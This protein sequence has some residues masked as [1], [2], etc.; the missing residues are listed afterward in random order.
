MDAETYLGFRIHHY[1][2]IQQNFLLSSGEQ[3]E[4]LL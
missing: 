2:A 4:K 3:V 1:P